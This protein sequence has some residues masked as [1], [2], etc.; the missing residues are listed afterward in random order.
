MVLLDARLPAFSFRA[1][2]AAL[3]LAM[4]L[5]ACNGA[6]VPGLVTIV[7]PL[8][9]EFVD[10]GCSGLES[11]VAN[12][13]ERQVVALVCPEASPLITLL[14]NAYLASR[15][16]AG[17]IGAPV[18]VSRWLVTGTDPRTPSVGAVRAVVFGEAG[19]AYVAAHLTGGTAAPLTASNARAVGK[20]AK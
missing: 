5:P 1:V 4:L 13:T 6:V 20:R 10:L 2:C 14:L 17:A 7:D 12:L 15:P 18:D 8:V 19:A 3:L 16:D 9:Q 11:E